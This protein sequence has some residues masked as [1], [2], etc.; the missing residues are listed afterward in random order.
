MSKN[1]ETVTA[2]LNFGNQGTGSVSATVSRVY[3]DTLL[4]RNGV[5]AFT[6]NRLK[7][8][9]G[10]FFI[11]DG[12]SWATDMRRCTFLDPKHMNLRGGNRLKLDL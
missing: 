6:E 12:F 8:F 11:F 4:Y 10:T 7:K 9:L 1:N 2:R 3:R 5:D